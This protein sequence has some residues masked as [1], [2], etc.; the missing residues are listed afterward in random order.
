MAIKASEMV[1]K[2]EEAAARNVGVTQVTFDGQTVTYDRKQLM[3]ELAHWTREAAKQA[4]RRPLFRGVDLG[5]AW[6]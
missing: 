3:E 6:G 4:G 2:L 5:S 1:R